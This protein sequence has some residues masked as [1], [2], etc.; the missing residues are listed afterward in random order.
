MISIK[1]FK[2]AL[3]FLSISMAV[4]SGCTTT[5]K[6]QEVEE[7]RYEP[8]KKIAILPIQ[9]PLRY[10]LD[11]SGSALILFGIIGQSIHRADIAAKNDGFGNKMQDFKLSIADELMQSL[12]QGLA[13]QNYEVI[14]LRDQNMGFAKPEDFDYQKVTT[15]ADAVIHVIFTEMGVAS[16][17]RSI[18][19]KPQLNLD[20]KIISMKDRRKID[21][22]SIEYGANAGK[23]DDE[24]IPADPKYAWGNYEVLMQ[25]IPEVVEG[26]QQ[27]TKMIGP[28]I[29]KTMR[30]RKL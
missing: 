26:L 9:N 20:V 7:P 8:I 4:L 19:Y 18:T 3:L 23:P 28:H 24:N 30:E 10:T 29:A 22:W 25:K 1:S 17:L 11:K 12:E 21:D 14:V 15:D 6:K 5:G 27:G 16:P 13:A 2:L